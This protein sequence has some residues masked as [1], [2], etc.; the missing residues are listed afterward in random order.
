MALVYEQGGNGPIR[1][2]EVLSSVSE[3][4][5]IS[6]TDG[7][8]DAIAIR[9]V[10]HP[11]VLV[12]SQDCDLEQ[13]FNVRHPTEK[14]PLSREDAEVHPTALSHILLCDA[15]EE[16][17]LKKRLPESTG[18]KDFRRIAQNQNDRYHRIEGAAI[19]DTGQ[20]VEPLFLDFRRHLSIPCPDIYQQL[21]SKSAGRKA[22]LPGYYL[23]DLNHRF[24]SYLARIAIP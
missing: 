21:I 9:E 15:H 17:E 4:Q 2:A 13:D 7:D 24:H 14:P 5:A 22:R 11:L 8:A 3:F 1:Q 19:R 10:E 20:T 16:S 23:H 6:S 18:S 12:M